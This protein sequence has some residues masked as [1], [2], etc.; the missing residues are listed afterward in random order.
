VRAIIKELNKRGAKYFPGDDTA[1]GDSVDTAYEKALMF[2]EMNMLY[3]PT[4]N[5]KPVPFEKAFA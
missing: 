4:N 5:G 2:L 3:D 1:E